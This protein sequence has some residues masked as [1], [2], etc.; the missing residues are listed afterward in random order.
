MINEVI[1]SNRDNVVR[2]VI[3]FLQLGDLAAVTSFGNIVCEISVEVQGCR[4][5]FP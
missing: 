2:D 5:L 1:S 4:R 3:C